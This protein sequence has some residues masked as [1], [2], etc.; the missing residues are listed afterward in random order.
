MLHTSGGYNLSEMTSTRVTEAEPEFLFVY[1][2]LMR[3]FDL[4][5]L[6]ADEEYLGKATTRGDLVSLGDYPGLI[7]G[8]GIVQ[9]ELYRLTDLTKTLASVDESEK[10]DPNDPEHSLYRRVPGEIESASLG[11]VRAWL[12]V[13]NR[14]SDAAPRIAHGDWRRHVR[15]HATLA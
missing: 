14:E 8:P 1:G 11:R 4:N 7:T 2:L 15:E 9:G 13:F 3:G 6:L 10:F 12:Y 5:A